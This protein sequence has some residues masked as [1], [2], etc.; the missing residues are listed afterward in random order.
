MQADICSVL[1]WIDWS[2]PIQT[3]WAIKYFS[4]AA[5][6]PLSS[7]NAILAWYAARTENLSQTQLTKAKNSWAVHKYRNKQKSKL[8]SP[9]QLSLPHDVLLYI[10]KTSKALNITQSELIEGIIENQEELFNKAKTKN[11]T[12]K[13]K[14]EFL[15]ERFQIQHTIITSMRQKIIDLEDEI[16]NLKKQA[17]K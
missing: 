16:I 7:Y 5:G 8:K 17:R 11:E 10:R 15:N 3:R 1:G 13:K 14:V 6:E 12:L 2:D 9:I 4:K